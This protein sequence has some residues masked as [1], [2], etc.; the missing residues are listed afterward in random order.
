M[1]PEYADESRGMELTDEMKSQ[2]IF[3]T[4]DGSWYFRIP[5]R[6][7]SNWKKSMMLRIWK[8]INEGRK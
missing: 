6:N 8:Q 5:K 3:T 7:M 4:V 2:G 1:V